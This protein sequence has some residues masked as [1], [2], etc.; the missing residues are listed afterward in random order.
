M[1]KPRLMAKTLTVMV[2]SRERLETSGQCFVKGTGLLRR[3]WYQYQTHVLPQ[4]VRAKLLQ[5]AHPCS[6]RPHEVGWRTAL[7][8]TASCLTSDDGSR[9]GVYSP[10]QRRR[11]TALRRST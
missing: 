5:G 1:K 7:A 11:N 6:G 9:D 10:R 3:T 2:L 8:T 4:R